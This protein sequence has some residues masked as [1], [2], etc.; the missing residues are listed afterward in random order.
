MVNF[1][2]NLGNIGEAG[3][4]MR[5]PPGE[6]ARTIGGYRE[7]WG[8]LGKLVT[9]LDMVG[10]VGDGSAYP[11]AP[12]VHHRLGQHLQH[13]QHHPS[14]P[15]G[16]VV[17]LLLQRL[18]AVLGRHRHLEEERR[19]WHA[20]CNVIESPYWLSL[21]A[22]T[23]SSIAT[24]RAPYSGV[25]YMI[26]DVLMPANLTP[27]GFWTT[28]NFAGINFATPGNGITYST[29]AG[30]Q[31]TPTTLPGMGFTDFL[32]DKTS[33]EGCRGWNPWTGWILSSDAVS[34]WAWFN[35]DT[36]NARSLIVDILMRSSPCET[37]TWA[38]ANSGG[39]HAYPTFDHGMEGIHALNLMYGGVLGLSGAL[40]GPPSGWF[41]GQHQQHPGSY[42]SRGPGYGA[43]P[44][45]HMGPAGPP[46]R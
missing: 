10:M 38:T 41:Q 31:G 9:D 8:D 11:W 23:Q 42:G 34:T 17:H 39:W 20:K 5:V 25:N 27:F 26:L 15:M 36:I 19:L 18:H 22:N 16:G 45:G 7:M 35:P 6:L 32:E 43:M 2:D 30:V 14:H 44:I 3:D 4:V 29:A 33:P 24:V 21:A 12:M 1:P 28:I 37:T 46:L 13:H 40:R